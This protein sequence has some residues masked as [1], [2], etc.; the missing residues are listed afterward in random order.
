MKPWSYL[1]T[2]PLWWP[3]QFFITLRWI[4]LSSILPF[5][6]FCTLIT[7]LSCRWLTYNPYSLS[8]SSE[9]PKIE[10]LAWEFEYSFLPRP[11]LYPYLHSILNPNLLRHLKILSYFLPKKWKI[12]TF[13]RNDHARIGGSLFDLV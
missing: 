13:F 8:I 10:S 3:H 4:S 7:I 9:S 5:F 1:L 12:R 6:R 11:F 2:D